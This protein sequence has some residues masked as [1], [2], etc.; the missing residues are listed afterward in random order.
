MNKKKVAISQSNYIPWKGYFDL[1]DFVDEFILYDDMQYTKRDWRNRNLI[2]TPND[3][4]WLTVPVN[5][6]GKFD[7]KI[8][9]TTF[10]N[11]FWRKEHWLKLE[12]N[13]KRSKYFDEISLFLKPLYTDIN[14]NNLSELNEK[15]IREICKYLEIDTVISR[16][17]DYELVDGKTE[18][19]VS[20]CKQAGAGEY[21]SGP[22][23]KDYVDQ[24]LFEEAKIRLRFFNFSGYPEYDQLWNEFD[25][26]VSI[27]D[28]LFNSGEESRSLF[29]SQRIFNDE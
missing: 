23:A 15:F 8:F 26:N 11:D 24:H 22:A 6:K 25:H 2:K 1:I 29:R 28:L 13:Y 4:L 27:L 21:I 12:S 18:R 16:S 10:A 19:L 9:E 14:Y 3:N 7:Q 17:S 5:V 20:I